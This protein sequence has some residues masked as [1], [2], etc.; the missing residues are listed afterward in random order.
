MQSSGCL[1][2][3]EPRVCFHLDPKVMNSIDKIE[4]IYTLLELQFLTEKC[5]YTICYWIYA[6]GRVWVLPQEI[7]DADF[8]LSGCLLPSSLN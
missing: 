5:S 4:V 1:G 8:K 6:L 2:E 7:L 3:R